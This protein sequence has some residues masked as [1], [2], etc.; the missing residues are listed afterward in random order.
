MQSDLET[1]DRTLVAALKRWDLPITPDR[2]DQLR[3]HFEAVIEANR[4]MN[5]TRI[6][7]PSEAA[8][9][10]Y[11]DSLALLLLTRVEKIEVGEVL[12]IGTG[13]GFP[14]VPLAVMRPDWEVTAVDATGKKV[15]FLKRTAST[16]GLTNLHLQHAHSEHWRP[17]RRFQVVVMR[18]V[19]PLAKCLRQAAGHVARGGRLVAYKTAPLG[20]EELDEA[21]ALLPRLRLRSREPYQYHL[22]L[23]DEALRRALHVYRK[24]R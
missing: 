23:G 19:A 8:I 11:A 20:E 5:L 10:H 7:D 24:V 15:D 14:S 3:S 12:D 1:F 21:A 16:L 18:A 13:A 17:G 4:T 9:K 22:V 6:T 2:L